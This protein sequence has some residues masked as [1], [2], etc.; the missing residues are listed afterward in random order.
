[1]AVPFTPLAERYERGG[2]L[3]TSNLPFSHWDQIFKGRRPGGGGRRR[4]S[5]APGA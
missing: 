5:P 1:M 2:V 3:L 4:G